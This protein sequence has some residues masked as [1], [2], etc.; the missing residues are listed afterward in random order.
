MTITLTKTTIGNF[1]VDRYQDKVS[2]LVWLLKGEKLGDKKRNE[3]VQELLNVRGEL[4]NSFKPIVQLIERVEDEIKAMKL[5]AG[6]Y[7][8]IYPLKVA[9][10]ETKVLK[11]DVIFKLIRKRGE[12]PINHMKIDT[13]SSLVKEILEDCPESY[14]LKPGSK[15]HYFK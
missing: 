9:D 8:M 4:L 6:N 2:E 10:T 7:G 12:D 5:P 13:T 11:T 1:D 3:Y 14:T 15:K